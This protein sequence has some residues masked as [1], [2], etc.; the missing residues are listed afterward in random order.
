MACLK[1]SGKNSAGT[2][3]ARFSEKGRLIPTDLRKQSL[4]GLLS[5]NLI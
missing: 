5:G 2:S 3:I 4:T 1:D